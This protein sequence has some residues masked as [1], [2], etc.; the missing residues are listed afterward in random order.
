MSRRSS[1]KLLQLSLLQV[2]RRI[3]FALIIFVLLGFFQ[4]LIWMVPFRIYARRL[5][6]TYA[7]ADK[8]VDIRQAGGYSRLIGRMVAKVAKITPWP[9]KC[10]VQ[11]LTVKFLLRR[12]EIANEMLIGV[13]MD[14]KHK[15]LAHAWV[16][17][18]EITVVGGANSAEQF[19]VMKIFR[20]SYGNQ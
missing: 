17:V 14:D 7:Q 9:S 5:D 12:F 19:K 6:R 16:N 18:F 11:A 4:V 13:A 8:S 10:L 2:M 1:H 15:L 20:D 3:I